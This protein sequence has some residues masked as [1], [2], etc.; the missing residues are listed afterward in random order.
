MVDKDDSLLDALN[1]KG[2][3]GLSGA[4][5]TLLR[6]AVAALLNDAHPE[7]NYPY[8]GDIISDVNDAL[9]DAVLEPE[10]ED[11]RDILLD[12][13]DIFDEFNN[14]ECDDL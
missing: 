7:I 2:G 9:A 11:G 12:L 6:A 10:V 1:Y 8:V 5:Q 4:A 14:L 13:K 3:E